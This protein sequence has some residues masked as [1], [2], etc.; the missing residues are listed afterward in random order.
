[1]FIGHL[2][3]F[4]KLLVCVHVPFSFPVFM[5]VFLTVSQNLFIYLDEYSFILYTNLL[6]SQFIFLSIFF[7][8]GLKNLNFAAWKM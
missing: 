2:S 4:I 3:F 6:L 7:T 5:I 1:M 8:M